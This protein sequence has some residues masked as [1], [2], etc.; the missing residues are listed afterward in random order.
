MGEFRWSDDVFKTSGRS[1]EWIVRG[2]SGPH[3]PNL[4]KRVEDNQIQCVL[5]TKYWLYD[6]IPTFS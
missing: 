5:G 4:L 3:C 2:W 6:F 1:S